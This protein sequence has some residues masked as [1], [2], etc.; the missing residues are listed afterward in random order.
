MAMQ[1]A[2]DLFL[3]ELGD[4]YDAEQRIAQTLPTLEQ[5]AANDQARQAFQRHLQETRQHI[6]NLEQVFQLLGV[7]APKVTCTAIQGLKAEH[8]SFVK[9][10][11]TD[12]V[13]GMFDIGAAAKTEHYEIASYTGLIEKASLMGQQQV[14]QLLQQN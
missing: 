11:P 7:Q 5:E 1:T 13:L 12:E 6:S 2:Q 10:G 9:E 4:M 8:D 3:H 14:A